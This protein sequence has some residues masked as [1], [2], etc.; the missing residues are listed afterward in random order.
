MIIGDH[1]AAGV[2]CAQTQDACPCLGGPTGRQCNDASGAQ[3]GRAPHPHGHQRRPRRQRRRPG[4]LGPADAPA[5]APHRHACLSR[6]C[7]VAP[8]AEPDHA[9]R[10]CVPLHVHRVLKA[11]VQKL[12]QVYLGICAWPSASLLVPWCCLQEDGMLSTESQH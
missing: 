12:E 9:G 6:G 5:R 4:F 10:R 3:P 8:Q 1:G 2:G 11:A 7:A